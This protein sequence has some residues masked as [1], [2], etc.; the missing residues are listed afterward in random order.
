MVA[1]RLFDAP[2]IAVFAARR[3]DAFLPAPHLMR[4]AGLG[5]AVQTGV[6]RTARLNE[7]S[8]LI[9]GIRPPFKDRRTP[10]LSGAVWLKQAPAPL[11]S[12][13]L[14]RDRADAEESFPFG[15]ARGRQIW[16]AER[17]RLPKGPAKPCLRK[18]F[19]RSIKPSP[20][21]INVSCFTILTVGMIA[22][23]PH[24][25]N[26]L[27]TSGTSRGTN[28]PGKSARSE[29]KPGRIAEEWRENGFFCP[30]SCGHAVLMGEDVLH[31]GMTYAGAH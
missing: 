7:F 8:L 10:G 9:Q 5:P 14:Q 21:I 13:V 29:P 6:S 16:T 12:C 31:Y 18:G 1:Q 30:C 17:G 22:Q 24:G 11:L 15:T 26:A 20:N 4:P 2:V 19:V 25:F 23:H 3:C 27:G 28:G